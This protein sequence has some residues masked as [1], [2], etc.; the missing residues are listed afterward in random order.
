[1]EERIVEVEEVF[2]GDGNPLRRLLAACQEVEGMD[3][4]EFMPP[5]EKL[6]KEER[7]RLVATLE[8][9]SDRA[10]SRLDIDQSNN[11]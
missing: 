7:E 11:L 4:D 3:P 2:A 9:M 6:S 1:M 8:M 10:S 5:W